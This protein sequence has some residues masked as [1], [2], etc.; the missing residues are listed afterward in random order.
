MPSDQ[1][2][3]QRKGRPRLADVARAAGVSPSTA[4]RVLNGSDRQVADDL[5]DRVLKAAES[6]G[7][8][9]NL[10]AQAT[11]RGHYPAIGLVVGDIRNQFFARV[12]FGATREATKRGL[13]VNLLYTEGDVER[14][15]ELIMELRR[16]RP[17]SLVL[18]RM[19]DTTPS[20]DSALMR[21]LQSFER[22]GGRV[23]VV[24]E[25]A[26]PVTAIRPPDFDGARKLATALIDRGYRR[27]AA[28]TLGEPFQSTL[29]RLD[30]F[31]AGLSAAGVALPDRLVF[32][33][34]MLHGEVTIGGG[35]TATQNYLATGEQVELVFALEDTMA[36]GALIEL[37]RHDLVVP[38]DIAIAGYGGR[39]LI[40]PDEQARRLTSVRSPLEEM[41]AAGVALSLQPWPTS[42]PALEATVM[43]GDTTP[44]IKSTD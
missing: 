3:Q 8:T 39:G 4:S 23:V 26:D 15:R 1:A 17:Q 35:M 12:T 2:T 41:G 9:A 6:I 30:G 38:R 37:E 13:V 19:R 29:D 21:E 10:A 44:E 14:E 32:P 11:A 33:A 27:F 43:I 31:R 36:L 34:P 18:V 42:P 25:S 24:G 28:I 7:Y 22:E 20:A 5:R 40:S 16:Q